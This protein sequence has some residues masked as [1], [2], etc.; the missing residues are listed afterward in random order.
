MSIFHVEAV[1]GTAVQYGSTAAVTLRGR[2]PS[3]DQVELQGDVFV[4]GGGVSLPGGGIFEDL[5]GVGGYMLA[6]LIPVV[7]ILLFGFLSSPMRLTARA[8]TAAQVQAAQQEQEQEW[9]PAGDYMQALAAVQ[10]KQRAEAKAEQQAQ[11]EHWW[12]YL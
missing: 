2:L 1:D 3:G 9:L 8:Q 10:A 12:D 6:L 7:L 4:S 11:Q 5:L